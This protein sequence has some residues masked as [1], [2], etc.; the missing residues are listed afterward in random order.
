MSFFNRLFGP[1]KP[2]VETRHPRKVFNAEV[3]AAILKGRRHHL[4]LIALA[5]QLERE[6]E[7]LRMIWATTGHR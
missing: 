3:A 5:D 1:A 4:H 2:P 6:V 7:A